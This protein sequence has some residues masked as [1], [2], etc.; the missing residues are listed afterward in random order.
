MELTIGKLMAVG[1]LIISIINRIIYHYKYHE[2]PFNGEP[3]AHGI[4]TTITGI[5]TLMTILILCGIFIYYMIIY[6]DKPIK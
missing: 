6:W 5:S 4:W 1:I 3:D 2:I